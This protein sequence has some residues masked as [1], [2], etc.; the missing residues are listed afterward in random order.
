MTLVRY[1]A[2]CRALAEAKAVDEVQKIR[3]VSEAM[4]AYARQAKNRQLE[5]DAAE[6][7]MRAERRIGELMQ[8]QR[9]AGL[10]NR[11]GRPSE[12][13]H[14]IGNAV[15]KPATLAEAGIDDKLAD[16]ARKFAAVPADEFEAEIG[17]WRDRVQ[18]EGARVT[19][20]LLE[21]GERELADDEEVAATPREYEEAF[22]LR[23]DAAREMAEMGYRGPVTKDVV[24]LARAAATAWATLA[25]TLEGR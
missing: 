1:D 10:L 6:I 21:R 15:S 23:A 22:L 24:Q 18:A 17:E 14:P 4:R 3:N 13:P 8:A 25:H 5:I 12:K 11:G 7:R 19:T 9:D 16:R 20:R 2:A